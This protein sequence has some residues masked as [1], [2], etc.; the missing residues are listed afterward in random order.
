MADSLNI[1]LQPPQWDS[2]KPE[3]WQTFA[4]NFESFVEYS[5][6]EPLVEAVHGM[7][8]VSTDAHAP[9][10][11]NVSESADS[12]VSFNSDLQAAEPEQDQ[13]ERVLSPELRALDKK[14]YHVL[15]LSI[16]GPSHDIL[17]HAPKSFVA[18]FTL[19][20]GEHGANNCLR[21]T[22]LISKLFGIKFD[23]DVAKFKQDALQTIRDVT[24]V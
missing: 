17:L 4:T 9:Q 2:S 15:K 7:A 23:G 14:L 12:Q 10:P 11:T 20:Y 13:A 5:G 24:Q 22:A 21:K 6:G 1:R 18:A 19:L 3:Q 8:A 16:K